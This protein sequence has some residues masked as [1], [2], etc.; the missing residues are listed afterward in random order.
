VIKNIFNTNK[1]TIQIK[2]KYFIYLDGNKAKET[3]CNYCKMNVNSDFYRIH[4][5]SHPSKILDWLY[6]GSYNNALNKQVL[7]LNI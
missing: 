4:S 6:L 2:Y 5:D 7:K 3:N 1:S